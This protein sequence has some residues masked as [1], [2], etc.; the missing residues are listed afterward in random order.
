[1]ECSL[2]ARRS[3]TTLLLPAARC[4]LSTYLPRRGANSLPMSASAILVDVLLYFRKSSLRQHRFSEF[5]AE[6]EVEQE[7]MLKH[8]STRWLSIGRCLERLLK[9]WDPLKACFKA[10]ETASGKTADEQKSR[11]G[12]IKVTN[13]PALLHL[14][15]LQQRRLR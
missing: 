1:M 7:K 13:K 5:Q 12:R 11:V 6:L 2:S 8:V 9:N 4:T 10:E 14:P 15:S 3:T